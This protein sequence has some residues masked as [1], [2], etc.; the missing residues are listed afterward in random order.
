MI[1]FS[2]SCNFIMFMKMCF[3]LF[4]D[5]PY[6]QYE[7]ILPLMFVKFKLILLLIPL[8]W[9][10]V[11]LQRLD[12]SSYRLFTRRLLHFYKPSSGLFANTDLTHDLAQ[13][14]AQALLHFCDFL[15]GASEVGL[16][17]LI[18]LIVFFFVH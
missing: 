18:C 14:Y 13:V 3:R 2:F 1:L 7:I 16:L 15:L 11:S 5:I 12:D 8:Q 6:M 9:P 4:R 10:T 17:H